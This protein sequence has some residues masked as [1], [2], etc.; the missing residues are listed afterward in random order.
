MGCQCIDRDGVKCD[1][2]CDIDKLVLLLSFDP[3]DFFPAYTLV[4][5]RKIITI[6]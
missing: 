3:S 1:I 2:V 4:Y 5:H 6:F